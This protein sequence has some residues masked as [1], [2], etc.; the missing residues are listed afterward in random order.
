MAGRTSPLRGFTTLS[1]AGH[2]SFT[3]AQGA[4][5]TLGTVRTRAD[6]HF[7]LLPAVDDG[8]A[9]MDESLALAR[10]AAAEGT[11][12][13]VSTPHVRHDHVTDVRELPDRVQQVRER[14]VL[15]GLPVR[16]LCGGEISY[17]MVGCLDQLELETIAQGPPGARWLLV[18]S[19]FS[20]AEVLLHEATDE[21]RDRGF[22]V[23]LAHPERSSILLADDGAALAHELRHGSLLQLNATSLCGDNGVGVERVAVRLAVLKATVAIASDAHSSVRAPALELGFRAARAHGISEPVARRLTGFGPARLLG[24]GLVPPLAAVAA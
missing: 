11:G 8:P 13:I 2:D 12:T 24:A 6:I 9:T 16:V 7:H 17:E 10:D 5:V 3:A 15:E 18:E 22:G 14:I 19:P 1:P 21:L 20:G 4:R 23:V